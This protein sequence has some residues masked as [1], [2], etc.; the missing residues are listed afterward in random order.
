MVKK[1]LRAYR[2]SAKNYRIIDLVYLPY[3]FNLK[4]E[5]I[6][7]QE[8]GMCPNY[9]SSSGAFF[10]TSSC[11]NILSIFFPIPEMSGNNDSFSSNVII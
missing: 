11:S 3:L 7:V 10:S 5:I 1:F 6:I 4:V 8:N 9:N 2:F